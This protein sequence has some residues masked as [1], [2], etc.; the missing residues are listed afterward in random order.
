MTPFQM[1]IIESKV[2]E[3]RSHY[4]KYAIE[5]LEQGQ[6]ITVGNALRRVMLSDLEGIAIVA[7]RISDA[8][9]EFSTIPGVREDAIEILLNLKEI[10]LKGNINGNQIGR[11]K[12]QG[13]GTVTA[14]QF[15]LPPEIELVDPQQY[16]ATISE[17]AILEI[18]IHIE[19]GFGYHITEKR[20]NSNSLKLLSLDAVFMPVRKVSYDIEQIHSKSNVVQD[21]LILKVWTNGSITPQEAISLSTKK[22]IE[23]FTVINTFC[24]L[25]FNILEPSSSKTD[26]QVSQIL[27]EELH[28]SVRAYN[29]LKRAQIHSVADL[30][31]YSKEDLLEIK[32]FGQKSAQEVIDALE[33][34][35]NISLEG[36]D[37]ES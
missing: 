20:P 17:N 27:I 24:G 3:P 13:P 21:R 37:K 16:I 14:E 12:V 15:E 28:L 26:L 1:K 6:G 29:C 35:L 19:S 23:L 2:E 32:N 7:V 22:L 4:G 30:L 9:H 18:E 11:L 8:N 25:N 34:R 33:H 5:C 10:V 31:H 36:K